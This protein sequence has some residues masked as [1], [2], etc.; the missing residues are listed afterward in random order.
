MKDNVVL[1]TGASGYLGRRLVRSAIR[2]H[3]VIAV[4]H[5]GPSSQSPQGS[6]SMDVA[7]RSA[8]ANLVAHVRPTAIINT[9]AVN[10]GQGDDTT[11]SRVN[12]DGARNVAHAAVE[13]GVRLIH[14]ST[15]VVHDG[16]RGPYSDDVP[17]SP[18]QPYGMSKALGESEVQSIAP[19]ATIV[20]PSLIYGVD[21]MDRGTAGF[22]EHIATGERLTL[23]ADVLRN[24]I[25]VE[26]LAEALIRFVHVDAPG[27]LNVAG[28][29]VLSREDFG[30][31]MLAY[32]NVPDNGLIDTGLAVN[33][34]A[35]IPRDL[36]LVSSRAEALLD[37]SFPGVDD[38][39]ASHPREPEQDKRRS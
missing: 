23:F 39:L 20:R 35:A 1:I 31:K 24:P 30:R 4:S 17:P 7:D 37:M 22:A 5:S 36:R 6:L 19:N 11:M 34:S 33:V 10:P 29:Q 16:T 8:V 25:W 2:D 15:D 14:V 32:W 28:R 3:E 9:A 26:S 38:V 18:L 13:A 27:V 21:E 12:V